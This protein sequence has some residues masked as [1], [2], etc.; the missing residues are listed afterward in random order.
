MSIRQIIL[1]RL[2]IICITIVVIVDLLVDA[3]GGTVGLY[4]LYGIYKLITSDN[5]IE[6][7]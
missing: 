4:V 1:N 7:E 6:T 5:T 3:G 2:T